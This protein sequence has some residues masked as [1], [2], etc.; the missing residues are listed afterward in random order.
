MITWALNSRRYED[1]EILSHTA[2]ID[3]ETVKSPKKT[4]CDTWALNSRRYEDLD[5]LGHTA[6]TGCD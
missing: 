3:C 4:I 6:A 2:A 1:L 5:I